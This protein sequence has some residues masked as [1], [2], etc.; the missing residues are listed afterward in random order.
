MTKAEHIFEKIAISAAA[1]AAYVVGRSAQDADAGKRALSQMIDDGYGESLIGD[2]SG[3]GY[4]MLEETAGK[5]FS[6]GKITEQQQNAAISTARQ[7]SAKRGEAINAIQNA[8]PAKKGI[9]G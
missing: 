1:R 7:L 2:V 3:K 6:K 5:L 8:A 4:T 9:L